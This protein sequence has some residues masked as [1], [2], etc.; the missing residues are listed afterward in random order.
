MVETKK[1][2]PE[3]RKREYL[4]QEY[5]I[6]SK[7]INEFEII[8]NRRQICNP[9]VKSMHQA[10]IDG[11]NPIGVLI[12]NIRQGKMR[13]IDGN[14]RIE[15]I[16]RFYNNR[17]SNKS[18][19]I[20]CVLKI[21]K[22]LTD[23]EEREVYSLEAKR[24]NESY[25]DRITMYKDTITFWKLLNDQL[26]IFPC[27]VSI[28]PAVESLKFRTV[29]AAFATMKGNQEGGTYSPVY[30]SKEEIVEFAKSLNYEDFVLFKEFMQF[31]IESYGKVGENNLFTRSQ[32]FMPL[33]DI[34]SKNHQYIETPNF[35]ERFRRIIGRPDLMNYHNMGGREAQIN[36][37]RAMIDH[38]NYRVSK[39]IFV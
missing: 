19:K 16:K 25:E 17:E 39:N 24:R 38:M 36:V 29:L 7:N 18:V 32:F 10:I 13:L 15:S 11:K 34:Y 8:E 37:R 6:D 1:K 2:E 33:F 30:L 5:M 3:I 35:A 20:E 26:N 28:Y 21:Y 9:H 27:K 4:I 14:H 23:E 22:E 12:V 31:F